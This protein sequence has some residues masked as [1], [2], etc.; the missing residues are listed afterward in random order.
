MAIFINILAFQVAWFAAV[1][2]AAHAMPWIGAL[3]MAA[4]ICLHLARSRRPSNEFMLILV[5]GVIGGIWD[6]L[7]VAQGLVA[8]TSG[9]FAQFLAPYWIIGM[10]ML[11][12]TTLNISM[13][14]LKN[15]TLLAIAFG[16]IG[17]P[18]AYLTGQKLGGIELVDPLLALAVLAVGWG[19]MMPV[20]LAIATRLDGINV[21]PGANY[22]KVRS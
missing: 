2:S 11:F 1:L 4:V 12:A 7:L 13:A 16:A 19:G 3:T 6:S 15:R 5:C 9:M 17:G 22:A 18:L 14:W 10:W 21:S 8:Y 20:L